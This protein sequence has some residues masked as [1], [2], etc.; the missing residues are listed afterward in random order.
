MGSGKVKIIR[1]AVLNT[2]LSKRTN[3]SYIIESANWSIKWDGQYIT[4]NL[5]KLNL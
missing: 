1:D 3:L 5:N 2:F 4:E